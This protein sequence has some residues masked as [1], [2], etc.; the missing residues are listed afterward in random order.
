[1]PLSAAGRALHCTAGGPATTYQIS[2]MSKHV[3]KMSKNY[4]FRIIFSPSSGPRWPP[5]GLKRSQNTFYGR[6]TPLCPILAG[7]PLPFGA[8]EAIWGPKRAKKGQKEAQNGA[9]WS[10]RTSKDRETAGK[11]PL[12]HRKKGLIQPRTTKNGHSARNAQKHV[13]YV[14]TAAR[15]E[16]NF[17]YYYH[18]LQLSAVQLSQVQRIL[19]TVNTHLIGYVEKLN[20]RGGQWDATRVTRWASSAQEPR[21]TPKRVIPPGFGP[22]NLLTKTTEKKE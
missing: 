12:F 11:W 6:L 17:Y 5:N 22:K 20:F 9:K 16:V 4:F 2:D 19:F 8:F 14:T 21:K 15:T 18:R 7:S 13:K 10:K 1:L 3:Q